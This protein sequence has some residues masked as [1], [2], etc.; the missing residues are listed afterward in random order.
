VLVE[1]SVVEQRYHGVMEVLAG[2]VPVAERYGGVA[3]VGA[4]VAEPVSGRGSG[5]TGQGSG[6]VGRR[7]RLW[8]LKVLVEVLLHPGGELRVLEQPVHLA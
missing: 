1:L 8:S 3:Q 6:L 4:R 7:V 2:G 5:R